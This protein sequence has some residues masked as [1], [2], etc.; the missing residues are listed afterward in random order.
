M[1]GCAGKDKRGGL[2]VCMILWQESIQ[3]IEYHCIKKLNADFFSKS[4]DMLKWALY[5]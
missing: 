2:K 5:K 3:R 4:I 1:K